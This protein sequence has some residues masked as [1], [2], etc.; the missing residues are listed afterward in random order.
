[1]STE[2]ESP[3]QAAAAAAPQQQADQQQ[4]QQQQQARPGWFQ[5]ARS[6]LFQMVI[7]Y[8]ITSFFR[9]SK[10]PPD[11]PEG[12]PGGGV[13]HN[14]FPGGQEMELY[15]FLTE[16]EE[17]DFVQDQQFLV[18]NEE[19]KYG[20][21][22]DGEFG[23]GNR[24]TTLDVQV[25]DDVQQNGTWYIH[26]VLSERGFTLDRADEDYSPQAVIYKS[27]MF[28]KYRKRRIHNTAN[29]LTGLADVA[30]GSVKVAQGRTDVETD[31]VSYYHPNLTIN[32]VDDHTAWA[33]GS[34][35]E[36]LNTHILF[37]NATGGYFPILYLNDYWNL[38]KDYMPLND[39][40]P[41]ISVN[42]VYTPLSMFKFNMYAA[43]SRDNPWSN[44]MSG[45]DPSDEEQDTVKTTLQDT[46]PY[47]L[48]LTIAVSILHTI[49]EFL[50]FKNDVQFWRSRKS[51]EGLSVRSVFFNVFQSLVV[52]LYIMDNETNFVVIISVFIG[53]LIE[54]WKVT[55]VVDIRLDRENLIAGLLPRPTFTDFKSYESST[56][57]YDRL[58]FKYLGWALFPLFVGYGVYSLLYLEHKGWY[59]FVLGMSYGF[60]L[61]FGFITMTPQLFINYKLKSV[62]HLPW[63]ML[64]YKALNTFIDDI[65][66]FVIKM[67]T[68]YRIGCFRDD[69]VFFIFL[70]QRWIY[71]VDPKRVNE[72][73][74]SA[75]NPSG[76]AA[77]SLPADDERSPDSPSPAAA[78]AAAAVREGSTEPPLGGGGEGE[79]GHAQEEEDPSQSEV[80]S[81]MVKSA[82]DKKD[83]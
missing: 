42:L 50:A 65:F 16:D 2:S 61:T 40:T 45:P 17:F 52:L 15:V 76:N 31:I 23:D 29:L 58:A 80:D 24:I 34:I 73:G 54:L 74:T 19:L 14:L 47:L 12:A 59:S 5:I 37:D 27:T 22:D 77:N 68:M 82:Q 6:I 55:K 48:G 49:F 64:T 11:S 10:T 26:V 33:Q 67:P 39:T 66:A 1:M 30:P 4:Q 62:A 36:P 3:Q 38:A 8:F 41:F 43:M 18:W 69:I 56:R 44:M 60:L 9:G 53:L 7:F 35:P 71:R 70:Y 79:P 46:N 25:P 51:L 57:E 13:G 63:R 72:F 28:N 81:T 20:S 78:A 75:E 32:V 83:D 21:W